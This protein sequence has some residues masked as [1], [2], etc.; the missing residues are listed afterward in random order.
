MA[1]AIADVASTTSI[2]DGG[3]S[4]VDDEDDDDDTDDGRSVVP[5]GA[6][7]GLFDWLVVVGVALLVA[8][9]VRTFVLAHFVVDGTSMASTLHDGDRVFVNKLSYRLHD[10]EPGRRRG[11]HEFEGRRPNAT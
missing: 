4:T 7:A 8:F 3:A 5:G 11:A 1:R 9:L 6:R 10:P 2:A